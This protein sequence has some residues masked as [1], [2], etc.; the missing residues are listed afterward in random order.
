MEITF[1]TKKLQK[2]CS[3][4]KEAIKA[5]NKGVAGKLMQRLMELS[6]F[7]NLSQVPHTPPPRC[8][9]L[10][11]KRKGTFA[12]DL[13]H[14]WRLVFAPANGH[15]PRL[16]DSGIDKEQVTAIEIISIEDYH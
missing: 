1:R 10:S 7:E 16:E 2:T 6:A 8:H 5:F 9:E 14:P 3:Q 15:V 13:G 4:K 12:V 11:G